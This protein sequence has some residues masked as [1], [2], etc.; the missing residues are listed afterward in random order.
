MDD[1]KRIWVLFWYY[2]FNIGGNKSLLCINLVVLLK[3]LV[4]LNMI[5]FEEMDVIFKVF[6]FIGKIYVEGI[7]VFVGLI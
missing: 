3:L 2:V 4:W 7:F 1:G 6:F 5:F